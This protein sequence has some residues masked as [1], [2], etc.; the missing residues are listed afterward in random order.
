MTNNAKQF[1]DV[2]LPL[3]V[4]RTFH[5]S[6]PEKFQ[7]SIQA[8]MRVLVPFGK[9]VR[10]GYCVGFVPVPEV[11]KV[12]DIIQLKDS[13]PAITPPL[14]KLTKWIAEYYLCSWGETLDAVLPPSVRR[15]RSQRQILTVEPA[16]TREELA[17]AV[18]KMQAENIKWSKILEFFMDSHEPVPI[19]DLA[20]KLG[21]SDSPIKTLV[22]K[23]LLKYKKIL[24]YTD[25]HWHITVPREPF[26]EPT[27]H[28]AQALGWVYEH[29]DKA[30]FGVQLLLGITGS[31]KTEVYL[32]AINYA[33]KHNRQAIVLVPEIALTPQAVA[34]FKAR[35][36]D[37][38]VLHSHLSEGERA[39][40]WHNIYTGKSKVIVGTRSAIFAPA[41][42]LGVIIVDEE[43]ETTFKQENVPRYNAR[44]V[45]VMRGK[46]ENAVV[47][48]GSATPSL[49][50]YYN[51]QTGKYNLIR[52]P[53]RISNRPLPKV[54]IIDMSSEVGARKE[55][56][57]LSHQLELLIKNAAEKKEQVI[58][59]LN[60]RGF[61]TFIMC[62]KCDYVMRC[63][64]CEVA[65]T[66]HRKYN[67]ALCHYCD[68]SAAIPRV[69]PKCGAVEIRQLGTGTEKLEDHIR[70]LFGNTDIA[71]M[72][73]DTM[74]ARGAYKKVFDNLWAGDIDILIGTQM[75]T[76]GFDFPNVT[77]VGVISGDTSLYIKDFRSAERTFQLVTQVAGRA[78]RGAK[79]GYVVIQTFNPTHYSILSAAKH[80]YEGFA[81]KELRFRKE[82]KYPP[83]SR[84]MRIV[85]QGKDMDA[86]KETAKKVKEKLYLM[87]PNNAGEI[88]GPAPA[89]IAKLRD[90][91]RWHLL[92]KLFDSRLTRKIHLHIRESVKSHKGTEIIF[93]VDPVVML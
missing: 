7:D 58:L 48:L 54:E 22:K 75:V 14:L 38:A 37:V 15:N 9:S 62:P 49:E 81:E 51:A 60:R 33:L 3:P 50:S 89:P 13:F 87:V 19:T 66:Y 77:L 73:S 53:I 17:I 36:D 28:Q 16:I 39:T 93:D 83:Y 1:A 12:K 57:I 2:A 55:V 31:G 21:I 74:R 63:P 68:E 30:A 32:H 43:H 10:T 71:R 69:C 59:F 85:V 18:P 24:S 8:G 6:V 27:P 45:A 61:T 91:H 76:K 23:G 42:N 34:R 26:L 20:S 46:I 47:I 11:P 64:H 44:D 78:G 29:L 86:V 52:L 25:P 5:Y 70:A 4:D 40:Q 72:D 79:S 35:F 82:L 65:M 90:K 80:D 56:P 88:L 92:M 84:V 67:K 41:P